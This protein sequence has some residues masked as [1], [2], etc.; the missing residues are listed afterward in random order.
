MT[1]SD[2]E[3]R[4]AAILSAAKYGRDDLLPK[5]RTLATHHEKAQLEACAFALGSLK[6]EKSIPKLESLARS[7]VPHIRLAAWKALYDLGRK[8]FKLPLEKAAKDKD[9]YA[10]AL[11]GDVE[12]SQDVLATLINDN[13]IQVKINAAVSLLH[14]QDPRCLASLLDILIMDARGLCF[15]QNRL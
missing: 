8:E 4:I 5:I 11:L 13:N 1:N 14:L 6:D 15:F 9:I 10:I 3:V 7:Q 12:G 2:E